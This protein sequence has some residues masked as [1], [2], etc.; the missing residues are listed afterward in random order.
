MQMIVEA[1]LA[2]HIGTCIDADT[3]L[4]RVAEVGDL[5][6]H[7]SLQS[8]SDTRSTLHV[9]TG[10][11]SSWTSLSICISMLTVISSSAL[12]NII[13]VKCLGWGRRVTISEAGCMLVH[14]LELT[15]RARRLLRRCNTTT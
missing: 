2:S 8:H 11:S 5:R 9:K 7:V 1:A 15:D 13:N 10:D 6:S 3:F 14:K 4:V 12:T